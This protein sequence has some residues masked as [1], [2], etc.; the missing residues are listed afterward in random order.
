MRDTKYLFKS[1]ALYLTS[2]FVIISWLEYLIFY[3]TIYNILSYNSYM[4]TKS[5]KSKVNGLKGQLDSCMDVRNCLKKKFIK[6]CAIKFEIT[7]KWVT[8]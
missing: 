1:K 2:E 8:R 3:T 5:Y 7:K 4:N 6:I